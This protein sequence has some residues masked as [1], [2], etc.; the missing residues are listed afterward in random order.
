MDERPAVLCGDEENGEMYL[1]RLLDASDRGHEG[2]LRPLVRILRVWRY[3]RQR[4]LAHPEIPLELPPI[5][6]GVICRMTV[7]RAAA[8]EEMER[9]SSW[10]ESRDAA[11][12]AAFQEAQ[13]EAERAI[14]R[15]H[16][17]GVFLRERRIL[18]Y[19]PW[20]WQR[21]DCPR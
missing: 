9:F 10:Q 3:P 20:E 18:T 12:A 6:E 2:P 15:R 21:I 8:E 13:S 14:L 17:A 1:A 11:L 7:I 19:R 16:K 4:A 5:E